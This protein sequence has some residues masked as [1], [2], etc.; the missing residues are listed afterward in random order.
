M[1]ESSS[2]EN[3][4]R[5]SLFRL[6]RNSCLSSPVQQFG[7]TALHSLTPVPLAQSRNL[8]KTRNNLA[9]VHPLLTLSAATAPATT[10]VAAGRLPLL[11][12]SSA[13]PLPHRGL[14]ET[15]FLPHCYRRSPA[16]PLQPSYL[17]GELAPGERACPDFAL[18]AA[19]SSPPPPQFGRNALHCA[20]QFCQLR[21]IERLL[22]MGADTD[23]L[24][25]MVNPLSL[26]GGCIKTLS[27]ETSPQTS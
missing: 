15:L 7:R 21:L 11:T 26:F 8:K 4:Y 14:A 9:S 25:G 17:N 1:D 27:L 3:K 12:I 2:K 24:D 23:V 22:D 6:S 5:S 19:A 10:K 13:S 18:S 16:P 20:A